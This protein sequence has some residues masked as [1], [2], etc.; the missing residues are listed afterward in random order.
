MF[1]LPLKQQTPENRRQPL[2]ATLPHKHPQYMHIAPLGQG[3]YECFKACVRK[4]ACRL[5]EVDRGEGEGNARA[6]ATATARQA[7]PSW[8]ISRVLCAKPCLRLGAAIISLGAA[9]PTRSSSLP[10]ARRIEQIRTARRTVQF[11]SVWPCSRWGLPGRRHCCRR[12][13]SF[14]PPFHPRRAARGNL[15]LCGPLPAGHP[16]PGVARHRALRSADFPR[17]SALSQGTLALG[18]SSRRDRPAN[19]DTL[20]SVS[21]AMRWVKPFREEDTWIWLSGGRLAR[22]HPQG[23]LGAGSASWFSN[24]EQV[25]A[26]M[27]FRKRVSVPR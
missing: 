27:T 19:L 17:T 3:P 2:Y 24:V 14:T 23:I 8:P 13:W 4:W 10:E 26:L 22:F 11:A 6:V 16:A 9:L 1:Y 7:C 25:H 18:G 5:A 12:R 20:F 15:L 21:A